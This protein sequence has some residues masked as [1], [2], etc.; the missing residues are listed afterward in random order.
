MINTLGKINLMPGYLKTKTFMEAWKKQTCERQLLNSQL[1]HPFKQQFISS[2]HALHIQIIIFTFKIKSNPTVVFVFPPQALTLG[3]TNEIPG[4]ISS[5][6]EIKSTIPT[7][8]Y[9]LFFSI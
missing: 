2:I 3:H 7:S 6:T 1:N 4:V 8:K 5:F 9:Y